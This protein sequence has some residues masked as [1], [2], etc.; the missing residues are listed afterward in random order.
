MVGFE[1]VVLVTRIHIFS[2]MGRKSVVNIHAFNKCTSPE[3]EAP[4]PAENCMAPCYFVVSLDAPL[5]SNCH[6]FLNCFIGKLQP[7]Q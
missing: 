1:A 5:F 4:D 2:D 6:V 7:H 3:D